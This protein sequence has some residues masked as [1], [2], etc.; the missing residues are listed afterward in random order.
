M[1]TPITNVELAKQVQALSD[2]LDYQD[3]QLKEKN[4]EIELLRKK[5]EGADNI[6][7]F[8]IEKIGTVGTISFYEGKLVVKV[9]MKPYIDEDGKRVDL[10][11]VKS[12]NGRIEKEDQQI[13]IFFDYETKEKI[14]YTDWIEYRE[15]RECKLI[16]K[17]GD[18]HP[19][20]QKMI[21]NDNMYFVCEIDGIKKDIH[22]S[23]FNS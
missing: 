20:T 2:R 5:A 10:D 18:I 11:K 17:K 12:K 4:S 19:L 9:S 14:P 15:R 16:T 7:D 13:W 23:A 6:E 22:I 3:R 8:P 21:E 1:N